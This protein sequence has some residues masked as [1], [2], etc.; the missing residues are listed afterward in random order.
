MKNYKAYCLDLDG[1]VYRGK[2]AVPEAPNFVARLQAKGIEPFFVTNNASM[3]QTQLNS[4]LAKF[5]VVTENQQIMSSAIAAA[6]Y[7]SR[8]YPNKSVYM[9]GSDGLKD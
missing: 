3:T 5:G 9:I 7:I 6:K 2:E 1:T 4:K 8:W